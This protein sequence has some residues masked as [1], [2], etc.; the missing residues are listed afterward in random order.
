M[1][2]KEFLSGRITGLYLLSK[3]VNPRGQGPDLLASPIK[4]STAMYKARGIFLRAEY[5]F[6]NLRS[7]KGNQFHFLS[8]HPSDGLHIS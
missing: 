3:A 8:D 4:L 1:V 5:T 2:N 7:S 6:N